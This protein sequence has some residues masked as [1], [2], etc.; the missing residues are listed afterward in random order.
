MLILS[1]SSYVR[2]YQAIIVHE[3]IILGHSNFRF[4]FVQ[5]RCIIVPLPILTSNSIHGHGEIPATPPAR[6]FSRLAPSISDRLDRTFEHL[7]G[8]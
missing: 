2:G 5:L 7:I 3:I 6:F 1:P 4:L 8:C